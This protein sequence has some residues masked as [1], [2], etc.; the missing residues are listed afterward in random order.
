[1]LLLSGFLLLCY[2][3]R[4][5]TGEIY[6]TAEENMSE[7][8]GSESSP[9]LIT[10]LSFQNPDS[11]W[12]YTILVN[13]KPYLNYTRILFLKSR[14]G[15][16]SKRD[17]ELVAGVIAKKIQNGDMVPKLDKKTIDSLQLVM[18]INE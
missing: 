1:M 10:F 17:A 4:N 2:G 3:C 6:K 16:A 13:S 15:F 11:T 12:G 14:S 5:K 8:T 18:K 7:L 9:A